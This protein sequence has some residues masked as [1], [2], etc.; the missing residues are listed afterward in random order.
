ML[1][2]CWFRLQSW[3]LLLLSRI[4]MSTATGIGEP[5]RLLREHGLVLDALKI[6][7]AM[8]ARRKLESATMLG[9]G[10]GEK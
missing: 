3:F 10:E 4:I 9:K 7:H 1:V 8:G 2:V 5:A 6:E